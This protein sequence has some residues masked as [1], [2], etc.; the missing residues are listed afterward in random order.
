MLALALSLTLAAT[1]APLKWDPRIDLP[2]TGV[3]A[4]GWLVSEYALK[5]TLAPDACRWCAT[6]GFDTG[7]RRAFNP[8]LTASASGNRPAATASDLL[9]F[10]AVPLVVVGFDALG[11]KDSP[12]F[13]KTWA[14]D[15]VLILESTLAAIAA[16]QVVKFSAGRARPYTVGADEALL[17][18]ARDPADHN[19]SF[20]S[21]HTS[22]TVGLTVS[23]GMIGLLRGYK[24]AW[25]TWAVG[26]PMALATATLRLAADK[27]WMTDVLVGA[28]I[29]SAFSVAIPL[30]FHGREAAPAFRVSP[31]PNG[32]AVSGTF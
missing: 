7:V 17:A 29:G 15:L 21:G 12:E 6:N 5:G 26:V 14:V 28:A 4:A 16:T 25:L 18:Q 11:A 9:G 20:F 2:V 32:L 23:A 1:P 3:L 22:F 10:V 13:L 27:H 24:T 19:L 30:L 31:M 8:S